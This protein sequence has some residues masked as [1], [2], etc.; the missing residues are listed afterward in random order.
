MKNVYFFDSERRLPGA[1]PKRLCSA[2][3]PIL[4]LLLQKISSAAAYSA[5]ISLE[6]YATPFFSSLGIAAFF[7]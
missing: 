5:K 2:L 1:F 3:R 7:T 6:T 4:C